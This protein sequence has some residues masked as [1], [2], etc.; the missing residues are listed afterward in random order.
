MKS[1][2][3][4]CS[5]NMTFNWSYYNTCVIFE[6]WKIKSVPQLLFSCIIITLFTVCY[7]YLKSKIEHI[8]HLEQNSQKSQKLK[9]SLWYALQVTISFTIMLIFMT[10]NGWL[11][12]SVII[13]AFLGNYYFDSN[14][15]SINQMSL[16]CH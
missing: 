3:D 2:M 9:R 13:G 16:A 15:N 10:Y 1:D 6:W 7:E 14:V 8:T 5:M 4:M 11:M 12:L